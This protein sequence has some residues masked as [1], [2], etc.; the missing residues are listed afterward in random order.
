MWWDVDVDRVEVLG[1]TETVA[2]WIEREKKLIGQVKEEYA[3]VK[4]WL[5]VFKKKH[6]L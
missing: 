3:R 5:E 6:S 2:V 4:E 1:K